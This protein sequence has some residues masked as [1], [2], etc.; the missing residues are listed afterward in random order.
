MKCLLN[1]SRINEKEDDL[2]IVCVGFLI[3]AIPEA[4]N[5]RVVGVQLE[6][7]AMR[8]SAQ[9]NPS[10]VIIY[11]CINA[12]IPQIELLFARLH[13]SFLYHYSEYLELPVVDASTFE[14]FKKVIEDIIEEIFSP[15]KNKYQTA[16]GGGK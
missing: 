10:I 8:F 16:N 1:Y 5:Q 6:Q 13:Q 3:N 7:S 12:S 14:A 15:L 2:V 9:I 4:L 11:D